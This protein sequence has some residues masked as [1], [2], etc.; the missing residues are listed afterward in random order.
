MN[1][2]SSAGS[3]PQLLLKN[4]CESIT[5]EALQDAANALVISHTDYC[6]MFTISY[7]QYAND[8]QLHTETVNDAGCQ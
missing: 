5:H 1:D 6:N 2:Q 4:I 7:H 3:G 8:I